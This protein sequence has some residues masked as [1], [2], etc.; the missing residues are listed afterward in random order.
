MQDDKEILYA[1]NMFQTYRLPLKSLSSGSHSL[2]LT[3][4]SSWFEAKRIEA[5]EQ[6]R[7]LPE[8]VDPKTGEKKDLTFWNGVS[9]RLYVRKAQYGWGWDWG[10]VVMTVGPWS[11]FTQCAMIGKS[12][13]IM[14]R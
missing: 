13:L 1:T 10:P 11:A 12:R 5:E 9:A 8:N 3:F 7:N 14:F 2:V 6:E 4:P